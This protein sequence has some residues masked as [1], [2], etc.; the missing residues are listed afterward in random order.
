MVHLTSAK[1]LRQCGIVS[2]DGRT[3]VMQQQNFAFQSRQCKS[4]VNLRKI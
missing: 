1:D 3:L 4:S 2:P